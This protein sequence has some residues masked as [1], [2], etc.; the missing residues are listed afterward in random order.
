VI[1][2]PCPAC[3]GSG[4]VVKERKLTVRI[5]AGIGSGQQLRLHGEVEHGAGGG[6]PGDLYVVVHVQE[7]AFFRRDGDDLHCQIPVTFPSLA[8]GTT[9]A[10]PTLDG[11]EAVHVPEGTQTGTIFRLKGKGMPSVT[12]RGRGDLYVQVEVTTPKKLTRA[13]RS[14]LDQLAKTLPSEAPAPR[15]RDEADDDRTVFDRVKDIFS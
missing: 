3:A 12:G 1:A 14:L 5:P 15:R 6:P 8:L 7:H 11:E 4:Q 2:K 13:Q 9:L 10:V